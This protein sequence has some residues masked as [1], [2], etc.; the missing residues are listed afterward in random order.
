MW[1]LAV[2]G[3]ARRLAEV[4][5]A[6][7]RAGADW[8]HPRAANGNGASALMAAAIGGH[9][10]CVSIL[11]GSRQPSTSIDLADS[12][13]N[14]ALIAACCRGRPD[15]VRLLLEAHADPNVANR[16]GYTPLDT[17]TDFGRAQCVSLLLEHG[18]RPA[19]PVRPAR[20]RK[21]EALQWERSASAQSWWQE[22]GMPGQTRRGRELDAQLKKHT[23]IGPDAQLLETPFD[24]VDIALRQ[25]EREVQRSAQRATTIAQRGQLRERA[26][27]VHRQRMARAS[28]SSAWQ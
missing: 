12:F 8:G 19:P 2:R 3:D 26:L 11:L 16:R 22:P 5:T 27:E 15:C 18:A 21:G 7:G 17:A 14:T 1:H 10:S 6:A 25:H 24:R 28:L 23:M 9:K 4:V 20:P 13:G